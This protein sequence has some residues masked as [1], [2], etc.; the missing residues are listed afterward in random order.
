MTKLWIM[1]LERNNFMGRLY[2][3]HDKCWGANDKEKTSKWELRP[4]IA[5]DIVPSS[6]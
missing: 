5:R 1:G 3:T 4:Q 6:I 2:E